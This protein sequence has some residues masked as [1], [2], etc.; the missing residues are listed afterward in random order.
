MDLITC[1]LL[2]DGLNLA[3]KVWKKGLTGTLILGEQLQNNCTPDNI[4]ENANHY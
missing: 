1:E 3:K 2:L 4:K